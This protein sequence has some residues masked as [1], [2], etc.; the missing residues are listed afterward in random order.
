MSEEVRNITECWFLGT[1][2]AF[3]KFRRH[4]RRNDNG[5]GNSNEAQNVFERQAKTTALD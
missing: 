3:E 2:N 4:V 1:D 5:C